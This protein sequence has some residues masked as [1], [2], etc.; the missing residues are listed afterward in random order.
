MTITP[1][2]VLRDKPDIPP[3]QMKL[4]LNIISWC[5]CHADIEMGTF[6][7]LLVYFPTGIRYAT[8]VLHSGTCKN[9][10]HSG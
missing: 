4:C 5:D 6:S 8:P 7:P 10:K 9:R 2:D 3:A 1:I